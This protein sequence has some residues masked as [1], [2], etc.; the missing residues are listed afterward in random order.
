MLQKVRW[1]DDVTARFWNNIDELMERGEKNNDYFANQVGR[2]LVHHMNRLVG[3]RNKTILDYG[4][5]MGHLMRII[6]EIYDVSA[7]YGCDLSETSVEYVKQSSI[8]KLGGGGMCRCKR[9]I[10]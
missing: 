3:F 8:E 5:G 9:Y 2:E 4:C 7:V 1:T 10:L 6:S